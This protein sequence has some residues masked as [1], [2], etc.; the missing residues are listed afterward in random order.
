MFCYKCGKQVEQGAMFCP[1]CGTALNSAPQTPPVTQPTQPVNSDY[2][3]GAYPP[4]PPP[5]G[6]PFETGVHALLRNLFSGS[7]FLALCV[8]TTI[9]AVLRFDILTIIAVVFFWMLRSD[10]INRKPPFEIAGRLRVLKILT[11]I[12]YV[13]SWIAVGIL[14]L[15]LLILMLGVFGILILM[16]NEPLDGAIMFAMTV[17]GVVCVAF[18]AFMVV[19][20]IFFWGSCRKCADSFVRSCETGMPMFEKLSTVRKWFIASGVLSVFGS[21]GSFSYLFAENI[22]IG[23]ILTSAI[24]LSNILFSILY[25]LIAKVIGDLET[26][27]YYSQQGM[28]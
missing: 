18:V 13:F 7:A 21:L 12:Q 19:Y 4:P 10:A 6:V 24:F 5:Y 14:V 27:L 15:Y 16:L 17:V 22:V 26:S 2:T 11:I 1:F 23:V 28:R 8:V 25:F 3:Q 20:T 9:V